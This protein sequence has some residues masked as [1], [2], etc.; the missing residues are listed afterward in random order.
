MEDMKKEILSILRVKI[1]KRFTRK[2]AV[3]SDRGIEGSDWYLNIWLPGIKKITS[4][5]HN[6]CRW[7]YYIE[8]Q[9]LHVRSAA[10]G[11]KIIT[12]IA[13]PEFIRKAVN[14]ISYNI[15]YTIDNEVAFNDGRAKAY[16]RTAS[17]YKSLLKKRKK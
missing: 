3:V 7:S 16:H 8:G 14:T 1:N 9:N 15:R 2:I 12:E 10:D 6:T 11:G 17:H 5:E 4:N 13:D